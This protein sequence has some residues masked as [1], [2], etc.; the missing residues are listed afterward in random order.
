[1]SYDHPLTVEGARQAK[2]LCERWSKLAQ[3]QHQRGVKE[4]S[5]PD[6]KR[7]GQWL[8]AGEGL[9]SPLTRAVQTALVALGGHPRLAVEGMRLVPCVRE[10]KVLGGIDNIGCG[11]GTE[12]EIVARQELLRL[13]QDSEALQGLANQPCTVHAEAVEN[14][15]ASMLRQDWLLVQ[16]Y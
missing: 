8:A 11:C 10:L 15:T 12:I 14:N 5:D 6:N 16:A 4:H 9:C 7:L 3:N 13:E 1:M 2:Q